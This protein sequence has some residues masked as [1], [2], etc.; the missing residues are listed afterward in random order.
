MCVRFF[1]F[2]DFFL[3]ILSSLSFVLEEVEVS[4]SFFLGAKQMIAFFPLIFERQEGSWWMKSK[5]VVPGVLRTCR[6]DVIGKQM[7]GFVLESVQVQWPL[8]S[9]AKIW[10][11]RPVNYWRLV[12]WRSFFLLLLLLL[13]RDLFDN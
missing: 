2:I 9:V 12:P 5:R 6:V 4:Y 11:R 13:S 8:V 1:F 7:S 3:V 10:R